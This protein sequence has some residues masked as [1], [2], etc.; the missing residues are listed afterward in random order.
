VRCNN[1]LGQLK[2]RV[3]LADRAGDYLAIGGFVPGDAYA[4][5]QLATGRLQALRSLEQPQVG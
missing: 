2:E 3:D 4:L 1:A 5:R